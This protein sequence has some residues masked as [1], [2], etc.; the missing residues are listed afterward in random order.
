MRASVHCLL[1][2][3]TAL[4]LAAPVSAGTL[5][6]SRGTAQGFDFETLIARARRTAGQPYHEPKPRAEE[7]LEKIDFDAHWKI[8]FRPEETVEIAPGVPLQFFHTGKFF[9]Q[10]VK[11]Y[12]VTGGKAREILYNP[13]YFDIPL[14]SPARDLPADIGFAGFRVM[15]PDLETDWISFLGA[16]YFR[17]DG[18]A[19]QYGQS[20][21]AL[22]LDTGLSTPEE[23]PRFTSFWFETPGNPEQETLTVYALLDSP[24][25]SGA[26]KMTMLNRDGDGQIIDVDSHLFFRKPVQ[27]LGI[28][29]L[30]SMY[31]Y[32][33][34]NRSIG[35]DWRPEV[36]D[37]DGLAMVTASGEQIWRPL[38][39]PR[40]LRASTFQADNVK[41]FGLAQRDREFENYQDDGVF[42]N[43]RP[44]VWIEP[45]EPFGEGAVQLV[46]IPTD[47]EIYDNIVAYFLPKD[48]PAAGSEKHFTYR[49]A[50]RDTH[51]LPSSGAQTVATRIGQG[52]V[53]GQPRPANLI[54]VVIDFQGKALSGLTADD[55][56][57]PVVELSSGTPI[58]P[59]VLPVVGTDR[60]RL[61]FDAEVKDHTPIE[62][63]AYLK[64][65]KDVLTETW[66]GQLSHELVA[67]AD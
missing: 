11:L 35:R 56:V 42:Y 20:A 14:D 12:E 33:E 50:W 44:S 6:G 18:A 43:K 51:P 36:H 23:F 15:R 46:E 3:L 59:Y 29:P 32:S 22:A 61:V 26:Y 66:L 25:V 67:E 55:G 7:T 48:L 54:K 1:L 31:W 63:R 38:N 4:S 49:M 21:R 41:G 5:A 47:D 19:Q 45:I 9:K 37:T 62:A 2:F 60:W 53:P 65:D 52:G 16:A 30:T 28:A 39:N 24:S 34:T 10:P 57:E 40:G 13:G 17:T 8:S 27:R 64:T 58:D